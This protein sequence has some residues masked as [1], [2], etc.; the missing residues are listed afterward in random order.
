[1]NPEATEFFPVAFQRITGSTVL[2]QSKNQATRSP[3]VALVSQEH[4]DQNTPS[5]S[6]LTCHDYPDR[7]FL[8]ALTDAIVVQHFRIKYNRP[9]N[10]LEVRVHTPRFPYRYANYPNITTPEL[11]T[12]M[13]KAT[14]QAICTASRNCSSQATRRKY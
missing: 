6:V 11:S 13:F 5:N 3:E 14:T 7:K 8:E 10:T 9:D 4:I 2:L 12:C 1:M